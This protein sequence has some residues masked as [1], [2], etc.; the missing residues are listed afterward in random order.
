MVG[1]LHF[2]LLIVGM[3]D[4]LG[5]RAGAAADKKRQAKDAEETG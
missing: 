2:L 4:R 3:I 5:D 1:G